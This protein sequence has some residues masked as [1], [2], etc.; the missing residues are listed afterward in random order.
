MLSRSMAASMSRQV[1]LKGIEVSYLGSGRPDIGQA[2]ASTA[3]KGS[4]TIVCAG[5]AGLMMPCHGALEHLPGELCRIRQ[6]SPGL[7]IK[8]TGPCLDVDKVASVIQLSTEYALSGCPEAADLPGAAIRH[9]DLSAVLVSAPDYSMRTYDD[10][11]SEFART[12]TML[13]NRSSRW[14]DAGVCSET[15]D[16]MENVSAKLHSMGFSAV[17]AGFIDFSSPGIEEAALRLLD[18]GAGH[19]VVTGVPTLLHRHPLS[20][21]NPDDAVKWLRTMI[22]YATIS[23]LKPEPDFFAGLISGHMISKVLDAAHNGALIE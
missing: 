8:Y 19:I 12:A 5:A 2:I 11:T 22:P 1:R 6:N 13:S 9:E 7:D 4:R 15:S 10:A 14:H 20:V 3:E 21:I 17:E 18:K 16:F 23:Y